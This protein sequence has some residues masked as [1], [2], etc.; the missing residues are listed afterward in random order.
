MEMR[1][2][3]NLIEKR[4]RELIE[5]AKHNG[6]HHPKVLE[7]SQELDILIV[8]MMKQSQMSC[9]IAKERRKM[10]KK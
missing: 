7:F 8:R 10:S 2:L 4:K 5:L 9:I 3:H 1:N 6:F